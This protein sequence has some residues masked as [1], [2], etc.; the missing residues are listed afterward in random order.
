MRI[1]IVGNMGYVGPV[2]V[3]HLRKAHPGY[4][5]DGFDT[6]FFAH[7]LTGVSQ[8]PERNLD[9]QFYGDVRNV[10]PD[11][12]AGYDAVVELAAISN[13]PMG[14]RYAAVTEAINQKASVGIAEAAAR[15]GV[16]N[17]VFASSCSVYGV[18]V[19]PAR[20]EGDPLNPV[21]AYAKSKVGTEIELAKL[22]GNM[23]VTSLRFATACG[24]SDRLRLD[25]V[26]NDFVAC[27]LSEKRITVLSDGTPWRPLIDVADMALAIDWAIHRRPDIGGRNLVIN[28]GSDDRNYQVRDLAH[29]VAAAVPGTE[30]NINTDAPAD[31]RSYKVDF[32]LYAALA[33]KHQPRVTLAQSIARLKDGM[34]AMGFVDADFRN[35][36]LIRL[37]VLERHVNG[38]ALSDDLYWA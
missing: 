16:R 35:S 11:L 18:A 20:K 26:L 6:A 14:N 15:A 32:G 17:F 25:L 2:V 31:S 37:K 3:R 10:S 24:M 36:Q 27:A 28:A 30:V 8:V 4:V 33:P 29:A 13:D 9:H 12:V 34:E 38:G 19:G 1:L 21:T 7:C 5:I 22:D 23:V